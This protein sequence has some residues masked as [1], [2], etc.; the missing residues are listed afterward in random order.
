MEVGGRLGCGALVAGA[1]FEPPGVTGATVL[2]KG[3]ELLGAMV[4]VGLG[5]EESEGEA[6]PV[7]IVG[8]DVLTRLEVGLPVG[9]NTPSSSG[10]ISVIISEGIGVRASDGSALIGA[11]V[12]EAFVF[13]S[14][15]VM[16]V[17]AVGVDVGTA[18]IPGVSVG[19][20]VLFVGFDDVSVMFVAT[21]TVDCSSVLNDIRKDAFFACR[22]IALVPSACVLTTRNSAFVNSV[23]VP[24][25][26]LLPPPWF[27]SVTF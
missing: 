14:G 2:G 9:S 5:V 15:S 13:P 3:I 16:F 26:S 6:S 20:E 8:L 10:G 24:F 18:P 7:A 27:A 4:A 19:L 22:L 25:I 23:L 1:R 17:S 11:S 12:A 21:V